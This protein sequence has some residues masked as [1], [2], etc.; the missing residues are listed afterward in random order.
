M[1]TVMDHSSMGRPDR[2]AF[3]RQIDLLL[4]RLHPPVTFERRRDVR[5]AIPVLF[6]LTPLDAD[7]H[8]IESQAVTV[9]GKDISRR[10]MSFFHERPL[11]YRRALITAEEPALEG[12][13]AEIDVTWCRFTKPGWYESGGRLLAAMSPSPPADGRPLE[14]LPQ[15]SPDPS[16][17]RGV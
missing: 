3:A 9:V 12:F 2:A 17:G 8:P 11:P 5:V 13:A 6:R 7:R 16:A 15:A 1:N 4:A 10:G 14:T